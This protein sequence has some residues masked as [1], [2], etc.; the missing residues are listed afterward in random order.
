VELVFKNEVPQDWPPTGSVSL[1]HFV[2]KSLPQALGREAHYNDY[3]EALMGK[4]KGMKVRL[5]VFNGKPGKPTVVFF[6]GSINGWD[7]SSNYNF[8]KELQSRYMGNPPNPVFQKPV[9]TAA[10]A[11]KADSHADMIGFG[12]FM[13]SMPIN[14]A[15]SLGGMLWNGV[16]AAKWAGGNGIGAKIT[17]MNFNEA[18]SKALYNGAKALGVSPFACFTYAAHKATSEV[19]G[20]PFTT[21]VQQASLQTRHFPVTGQ[22]NSRDFVGEWLV[23]PLAYADADYDL[24][25]AQQGYVEMTADLDDFGP[26]TQ[27][28]FMAK[29]Y[30]LLSCG[31][32]P[33]EI[34]P[35]YNDDAHVLDRTLFMNNYGV[36]KNANP[37]FAAWNWNAPLWLGVNTI[38]V[39]GQTTT[40]VGS[41][42]WGLDV[43][44]AL[45]DHMETTLREEIMAKAP[46]RGGK[47]VPEFVKKAK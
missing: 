28:S 30:G 20:Q 25:K 6:A 3:W 22:G 23:G 33:F 1:S 7:G 29:A 37:A 41:A 44:E 31:A 5:H 38:N 9:I 17:A 4:P 43:V 42:F 45:R 27:R 2:P 11:A 10:A 15:V 26:R 12:K 46:K 16:R 8:N 21:I 18:E 14:L 36:R 47:A 24:Q 35:T 13:L 19:L 39:N 34:V 32:A 40:L